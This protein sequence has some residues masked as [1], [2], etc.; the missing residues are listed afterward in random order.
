M[1]SGSDLLVLNDF[2]VK[3]FFSHYALDGWETH[4]Q[5]VSVENPELGYALELIH[6]SMSDKAQSIRT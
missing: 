4:P 3:R 6:L 2:H 5:V 1:G